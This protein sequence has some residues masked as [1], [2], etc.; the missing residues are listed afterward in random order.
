VE[1]PEL[2]LVVG[3]GSP[4]S[5]ERRERIAAL[6]F[7]G[8]V[9]V[10]AVLATL[11]GADRARSDWDPMPLAEAA[12]DHALVS[13]MEAPEVR[14]AA[15]ALRR[16]IGWAPVDAWTRAVYASLL[17]DLADSPQ[18]THAARFHAEH[19]VALAPVTVPVVH[20][21]ALVLARSGRSDRSVAWT[22]EM[23][24]YDPPAAARL[25]LSL[26][27]LLESAAIRDALPPR[28]A[29]WLAWAIELRRAGR[30]ED[31]EACVREAFARWPG[32]PATMGAMAEQAVL[33]KDWIVLR[34]VFAT[35][36]PARRD[37]ATCI[38]LAYRARL[39]AEQGDLAGAKADADDAVRGSGS[40]VAVVLLAGD[41]MAAAGLL[42]EARAQWSRALYP[43]ARGEQSRK[44]RAGILARLAWLAD[45][46]GKPADSLRAW[47][48]VIEADPDDAVARKRVDAILGGG[49]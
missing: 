14:D 9:L 46:D 20:G 39:R 15:T 7:G 41:A 13:G 28:P 23:F 44:T 34:T 49:R 43:I 4:E 8:A 36:L 40:D 11:L 1:R 6:S 19:A 33:R 37:A 30:P 29:A 2:T 3:R 21:A 42:D 10:G 18:E 48:A 45:R 27:P 17:L 16:R 26:E 32:D 25:L 31:A 35:D 22:R 5:R 12:I 38:A 24:D 47:R